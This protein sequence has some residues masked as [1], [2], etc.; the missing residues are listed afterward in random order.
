[1]SKFEAPD[2]AE[3]S[4]ELH[5]LHNQGEKDGANDERHMPPN[6]MFAISDKTDEELIEDRNAYYTGWLNGQKQ[7]SDD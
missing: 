6:P 5:D 2:P 1:M 7:R 3:R 4:Q